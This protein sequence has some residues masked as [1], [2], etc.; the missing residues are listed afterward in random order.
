VEERAFIRPSPRAGIWRRGAAHA[1]NHSAVR[2]RR[3]RKLL[4][5]RWRGPIGN[6]GPFDDGFL[7]AADAGRRRRRIAG[8]KRGIIEMIDGMV[9]NKADGDNKRKAE[10][11]RVEYSSALHLF[12][13]SADGWTPR[14]LTC[15]ALQ[16]E[17]VAESWDMVL[18]HRRQ[19]E[20]SGHL[21]ARRSGQ[22]LEWMREL[23]GIALEDSFRG[24]AAVAARLPGLEEAV[25][26]GQ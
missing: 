7:S 16:G 12:P 11:A 18:D 20:A 6:R 4:V 25:S 15:S 9:I 5:K 1:R 2:G 10:R 14:V 22:A 19:M 24:H 26:R 3:L 17:G 8:I 21:A 13:A 23:V